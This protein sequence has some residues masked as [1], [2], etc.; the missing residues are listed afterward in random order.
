MSQLIDKFECLKELNVDFKRNI[1][2][3][4]VLNCHKINVL[5]VTNDDMVYAFGI[6][7]NIE[8]L[9]SFHGLKVRN[10][11]I[12]KELCHQSVIDFTNNSKYLFARTFYGRVY[13]WEYCETKPQLIESLLNHNIIDICC[14]YT[15]VIALTDNAIVFTTDLFFGLNFEELKINAFNGQKVKAISCGFRHALALTESGCV[16]SWGRNSFGQLDVGDEADR[17]MPTLVILKDITEKIS[18][19]R[20]HSL[21]LLNLYT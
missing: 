11:F 7:D 10:E 16:Y 2:L 18:C 1:K 14:G 15:Q 21:F 3:F 9:R 12:I 13:Y 17:G 6:E 20:N 5:I 19:G 8:V 4:Y